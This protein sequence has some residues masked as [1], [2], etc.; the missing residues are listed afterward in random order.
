M[1]RQRELIARN[2]DTADSVEEQIFAEG[3]VMPG[4]IGGVT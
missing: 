2:V 4:Q 1:R 3:V